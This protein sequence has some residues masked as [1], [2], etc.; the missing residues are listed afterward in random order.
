V[1]LAEL[2]GRQAAAKQTFNRPSAH[3]SSGRSEACV[4]LTIVDFGTDRPAAWGRLTNFGAR[5]QKT[6]RKS[7]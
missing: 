7:R 3:L 4:A 6:R 2:S 5:S 1:E